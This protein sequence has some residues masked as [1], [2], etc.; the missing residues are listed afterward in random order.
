MFREV[1]N[2]GNVFLQHTLCVWLFSERLEMYWCSGPSWWWWMWISVVVCVQAGV[3]LFWFLCIFSCCAALEHIDH[4]VISPYLNFVNLNKWVWAE[5][6]WMFVPNTRWSVN[7]V[8]HSAASFFHPVFMQQSFA[9]KYL[10]PVVAVCSSWDVCR[11]QVSPVQ[12]SNIGANS[13]QS[14]CFYC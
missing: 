7:F 1:F 13:S 10:P 2:C 14:V 3:W 12:H 4:P 6:T 8:L 5:P 11:Q 9:L